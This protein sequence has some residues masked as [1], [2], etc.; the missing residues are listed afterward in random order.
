MSSIYSQTKYALDEASWATKS[1]NVR[2]SLHELKEKAKKDE[3][4]L[5]MS[6]G[7]RKLL[8]Y[9]ELMAQK[10]RGQSVH[11]GLSIWNIL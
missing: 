3:E 5:K 10:I 4:F 7:N 2:N 9:M 11:Q 1:P 6:P 8:E